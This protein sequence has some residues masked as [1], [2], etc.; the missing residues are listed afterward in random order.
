LE[1][2]PSEYASATVGAVLSTT[3]A[4]AAVLVSRFPAVSEADTDAETV[5]FS[6][7][8]TEYGYVYSRVEP[9]VMGAAETVVTPPEAVRVRV[10]ALAREFVSVNV[11][12]TVTVSP[13]FTWRESD[14]VYV[15]A[16]SE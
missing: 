7:A 10:G 2:P 15:D 16:F 13:D 12:L 8:W 11:A 6:P 1:V 3:N 5:P 4:V 14:E 9:G